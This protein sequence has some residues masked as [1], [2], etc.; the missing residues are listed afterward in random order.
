MAKLLNIR[1]MQVV[2]AQ[3]GGECISE[4]YVNSIT[5][6]E[7]KCAQ[8]HRWSARPS[9]IRSG[10]WCP[11]CSPNATGLLGEEVLLDRCKRLA[12]S[13]G[14]RCLSEAYSTAR[15]HLTWECVSGHVWEATPDNIK[16]GKW[17]PVC[18]KRAIQKAKVKYTTEA[19]FDYARARGGRI[20]EFAD[21]DRSHWMWECKQGHR[22][23]ASPSQVVGAQTWCKRCLTFE[24]R[25]R[26]VRQSLQ[27]RG[28]GVVSG[29]FRNARSRL[30]LECCKG[31]HWETSLASVWFAK[32]GCPICVGNATHSL[33]YAMAVAESKGGRCLSSIYDNARTRLLW[34]CRE[35]HQ[36]RATLG[37]VAGGR[38]GSGSWCPQCSRANTPHKFTRADA[39]RL[40]EARGGKFLSAQMATVLK[41]YKWQCANGHVWNATFS[42]IFNSG[43][44]C[45]SC[46]RHL[47][48]R[49][50]RTAFESL[51]A[52][53]FPT[54]RPRWLLSESGT[55]LS[56]DGFCECLGLAFEHQGEQHYSDKNYFGKSSE[57]QRKIK[58]Y[59]LRK[60]VACKERGVVLIHIPEVPRLTRLESLQDFIVEACMRSGVS[61]PQ[62]NVRVRYEEAYVKDGRLHRLLETALHYK[63]S[64]RERTYFGM[65]YRYT[66]QCEVGHEWQQTADAVVNRR[67]WCPFCSGRHNMT[68]TLL[69]EKAAEQ[70]GEVLTT[71]YKNR[72]QKIKCVCSK[73]HVFH[74]V[75]R[76]LVSGSWCPACTSTNKK[77]GNTSAV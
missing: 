12:E 39:V 65:R 56:L 75:A 63:G 52:N 38:S 54:S 23:Q 28:I 20:L 44:W 43:T 64:L 72:D 58:E 19:C 48:E 73:G 11:H 53:K 8:G 6:L 26:E 71:S 3:R 46:S 70:G 7:W 13:R 32:S 77:I 55:Q 74:R 66:W 21:T 76:N 40:A 24:A 31:H 41:T 14:G 57:E 29:S 17:C 62:P 10:S 15:S 35:G 16:R 4:N 68:L 36:W 2:A 1:D 37:G 22:W 50:T 34:E 30:S 59:D 9:N 51:F 5:P 25:E 47:G 33:Q 27:L 45:P 69:K 67:T 49:L 60:R 18:S 42:S 61:P